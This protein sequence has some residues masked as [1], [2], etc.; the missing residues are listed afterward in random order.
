MATVTAGQSAI[1]TIPAGSALTVTSTGEGRVELIAG[2]AGAGYTSWRVTP[3]RP[4]ALPQFSTAGQV[5]LVGISG[6]TSDSARMPE[7]LTPAE[8]A[9]TRSLVSEAGILATPQAVAAGAVGR[10][11]ILDYLQRGAVVGH[12]GL[13]G[14]S[15]GTAGTLPTPDPMSGSVGT[16]PEGALS[17][18]RKGYALGLRIFEIDVWGAAGF[19]SHDQDPRRVCRAPAFAV[20]EIVT[21]GS[22]RTNGGNTYRAISDGTCGATA[23]TGTALTPVSD[24]AVGWLW[25]GTALP[26]DVT[27]LTV[28]QFRDLQIS[29]TYFMGPG[30]E[31]QPMPLLRDVLAEF[32]NRCMFIIE[33][34]DAAGGRCIA[35]SLKEFNIQPDTVLVASFTAAWTLEARRAGY[36]SVQYAANA[37]SLTPA[38]VIAAG[39]VAYSTLDQDTW[40]AAKVAAMQ[41]AGIRVGATPNLPNRTNRDALVAIGVDFMIVPEPLYLCGLGAVDDGVWMDGRWAAGMIGEDN[42]PQI[43]QGGRGV[44]KAGSTGVM[45][46][47]FATAT[48]NPKS[49]LMGQFRL[50]QSFR[51]RFWLQMQSTSATNQGL[52]LAICCPTDAKYTDAAGNYGAGYL[53]RL[54]R[55]GVIDIFKTAAGMTLGAA[56]ATATAT[57]LGTDLLANRCQFELERFWDGTEA[58]FIKVTNITGGNV[59]A[60]LF[61]A[62]Y[63]GPYM[64]M[65]RTNATLTVDTWQATA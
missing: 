16:D 37:D 63:T 18:I 36:Q 3:D 46:W 44:L 48:T 7:V 50:P 41:A 27:T 53:I 23:P 29:A 25:V 35:A 52:F 31:N 11:R 62:E 30:Y 61:D 49:V 20:G 45:G 54:R 5:R 4:L 19:M 24:G 64:H 43:S 55:S 6:T 60:T 40:T 12:R 47:G 17:A 14:Y 39:A 10:S 57:G 65:G 1:V 58:S 13:G 21:R 51:R 28:S 8:V 38:Q 34:K 2:A 42:P 22:Y 56:N 32:G 15:T 33:A 26:T 59:S 9:L